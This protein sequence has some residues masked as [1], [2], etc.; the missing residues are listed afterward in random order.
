MAVAVGFAL[1]RSAIGQCAIAWSDAGVVAVRL[2]ERR[3]SETRARIQKSYPEAKETVPPANIRHV[4][5]ELTALLA[6][7]PRDL[8]DAPIDMEGL[9][10]YHQ[11]VYQMVRRIPPGS[12]A[13]Y[14]DIA[15]RL[16]SVQAA[17]AVGQA[18][19]R[20]PLTLI[21]PCH[22]VLS[23]SGGMG[24]FSAPGGTV[25]KRRLLRIEGAASRGPG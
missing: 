6:G 15:A 16:G 5:D 18:L 17:R 21:V 4:I 13:C 23:S 11:R 25:T 7:E 3:V 8:S 19:A 9:P 2:P 20:N 24:G 10:P 14:G 12:T 1:F 22:R